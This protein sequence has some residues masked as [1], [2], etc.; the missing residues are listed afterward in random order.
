MK[1]YLAVLITL[2]IGWTLGCI[3]AYGGWGAGGCSPVGGFFGG[4]R[5]FVPS[6]FLPYD[7]RHSIWIPAY[8]ST[9]QYFTPVWNGWHDGEE[10][11][12]YWY[13]NDQVMAGYNPKTKAFHTRDPIKKEWSEAKTPPWEKTSQ[14]SFFRQNP[15]SRACACEGEAALCTCPPGACN[16]PGC[17]SNRK[18]I[19][20]RGGSQ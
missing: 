12:Q 15:Q 14:D 10:G 19:T 18:K 8:S 13:V 5:G 9:Y 16:C 20:Q 11:W 3:P 6:G 2:G 4:F 17:Q 1:R 7:D